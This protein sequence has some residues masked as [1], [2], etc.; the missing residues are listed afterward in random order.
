MLP[1]MHIFWFTIP[2]IVATALLELFFLSGIPLG[3]ALMLLGVIMA[4]VFFMGYQSAYTAYNAAI[5]KNELK[6]VVLSLEDA[7]IV[8]DQTFKVLFFNPAGERMFGIKKEDIIGHSVVP[9]DAAQAQFTLL[10]QVIYPSLAPGMINR[11]AAGIY[12]Q[13]V[14]ISF[15]DPLLDLRV[16]TSRVVDENGF[17]LGFMKI[18]RDRTRELSVIK[19]KNEFITTASHQLRTPL[20][21]ISWAAEALATETQGASDT[22]KT[23]VENVRNST[24]ELIAITEDLLNIAKIEEGHFGYTFKSLDIIVF[25][26][27]ILSDISPL[28]Q[29][30]G[31]KL[32]FDTPKEA[33]PPVMIDEQKLTLAINNL[34]E[35][36]IRYNVKNGEIVIKVEKIDAMPYVK[37]SVKDTGIGI[38]QDDIQKL[39][40]KFFRAENAVRFETKGSGLGLYIVKNIIRGHGGEVAVTSEVNRGT[41]ISFTLPTDPSLVPQREVTMEL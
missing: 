4:I 22:V 27:R 35:N 9:Q 30:A 17:L 20:T 6:G 5:E 37:V 8:Y 24:K 39:F 2:A 26:N 36:A 3:I 15:S 33:L 23:I 7:L 16:T 12:P 38:P 31:L 18:V 11:T 28:I 29:K 40:G 14:D 1:E 34:V 10:T 21:E 19:S 25:L 32:Y 41:V 13:V